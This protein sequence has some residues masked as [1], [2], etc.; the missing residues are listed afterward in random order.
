MSANSSTGNARFFASQTHTPN[1]PA[2]VSADGLE[3][4]WNETWSQQGTYDFD[5]NAERHEVFSIDT[6]PPTVSGS[7]HVGHVFSYSHTD[8]VA[9][10]QRMR[11]KAVFYPMGWDDNGLPTERRVQNFFGVRCDPSLPYVENFEPPHVGGEGK[12]IKARDQVPVSRRNFVELCERLTLAD[13]KQFEDLWRTL[14][15]SVDW[16]STYQTI[17]ESARKVAQAAFLRNLARGEAYQAQAPGL[18]DVTFQTAV[19]QAELESRE[20][21]GF[22]HRLAFHITDAEVAAKAAAAG[23]PIENGVDVYIETTRPE[24]LPA[25]VAL[26][27]HPDDERYQ[28]LFGT[29]VSSPVFGVEVPVLP[30]PEAEKDKGA[31]IAMCCTFGD[32]T[33]IDWWRDLKLPLRAVLRKDGRLELE[34]P[35]WI[36]SESGRQ[37][38]EQMAGKTT[39]SAREVLVKQLRE[40][41]EM[42]GEPTKTVR[43]TNFFE[44]G[45]KPLEIVTSRQW[46]IRNGGK[47]WT[48]PASGKDLNAELLERGQELKFHPDFMRVR[49]E[50]W[51]KGLNNDWLISRQRFFGVPFPLWYQVDANGD[52]DYNAIITPDESALPVDPSSDVPAGYSAEQ[53]GVPGGFVGE[54]DIMDTWATSSLSA[55]LVSG[56]LNDEDLFK[57]VYPMDIRPQGQD[58][59]RTW[60]FSSVVRA[61]L[62]FGALPWKHAGISGWILDSDHKKM[63][64]SKGNVVTPKGLLEKY[65]SDAVRY[66]ATSARLG[67]DAAFEEAQIKIGRRLAIKILNASKFA[68]SM[69]LPWDADEATKAAA[70]APSLDASEVSEPVDQ[71]MLLGLADVVDSA[72]AAFDN[73]EHARALEV[74]ESFFWTFC[75]DYIELIKDRAN[76]FEGNH[77]PEAVRS[78]RTTLAIAV[79]TFVRLFA[80]FMPFATEEVWSWYR[81]GSVHR[82]PWPTSNWLR[83]AASG[84]DVELVGAVGQVLASLRKLKSEAK[85]SQKTPI[86]EVTLELPEQLA[87]QVELVRADLIEAAKVTGEFTVNAS[88]SCESATVV[89]STLGQAPAKQAPTK[90]TPAKQA[91]AKQTPTWAEILFPDADG[92]R[93]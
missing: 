66:W 31:G 49:Y 81:T 7:L 3:Q 47:P 15:L 74:A 33:D 50:N 8:T 55:Q 60:L 80:P 90:Q 20:Y 18:W 64:K 40:S 23:A 2:K 87:K 76:D 85:T 57:R 89:S 19:A 79:D 14:G 26:V 6:P 71:A 41:G 69:G 63:S 36:T 38:Y 68:L 92:N 37:V 67:L 88:D 1:A 28:P 45:D 12:S 83:E 51:V 52:V 44:K 39:F 46:Y 53:R 17:G 58:I 73:F 34:T 59:I 24:L 42:S 30:H 13:E 11:G 22:Y 61:D 84:A 5:R 9:R 86:L 27:A 77:R 65:G 43:Q 16:S 25:C 82:A 35:E 93:Q 62:E 70:P 29:T 4:R 56:W 21:P 75:D 32:T 78:A 10:Y 48:N 54:L 72:T 91:P